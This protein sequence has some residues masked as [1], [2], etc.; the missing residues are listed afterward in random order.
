MT[1]PVIQKLNGLTD[2]V[3]CEFETLTYY[4]PGSVMV[5]RNGLLLKKDF[6]DG[7][8]ELGGKRVYMKEAPLS[9]DVMKVYY[10]PL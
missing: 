1:F 7:W 6:V 2:G 8:I 9:I 5:F 4:K 3:N 10:I